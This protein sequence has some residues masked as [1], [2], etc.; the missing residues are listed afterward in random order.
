MISSEKYPKG[1]VVTKFKNFQFREDPLTNTKEGLLEGYEDMD[2][3]DGD[4][5]FSELYEHRYILFIKLCKEL[6]R[7]QVVPVDI[8]K[9]K[10]HS[11]GKGYSGYFLMGIGKEAGK[12][13]SYHIPMQYWDLANFAQELEKAPEFDGHTSADVLE[14]LKA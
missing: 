4:H 13:I 2:A 9:S 14:R 6:T 8:W 7:P 3:S 12:Q 10:V 1:I 5:T 11:D